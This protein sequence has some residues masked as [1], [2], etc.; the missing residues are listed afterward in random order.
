MDTTLSIT[1]TGI[2]TPGIGHE[3]TPPGFHVPQ[4]A[5]WLLWTTARFIIHPICGVLR[6]QGYK[7]PMLFLGSLIGID[8]SVS[9]T[10]THVHLCLGHS[11]Y[12]HCV[13]TAVG[14]N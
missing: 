10:H 11:V 1:L 14:E 3:Y 6:Q 4:R 12:F 7:A 5:R 8:Q 2:L 9:H 13:K